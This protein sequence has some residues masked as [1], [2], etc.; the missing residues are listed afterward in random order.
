MTEETKLKVTG[1]FFE[2]RGKVFAT[3]GKNGFVE[4]DETGFRMMNLGLRLSNSE[5]V[6]VSLTAN[7]PKS[8]TDTKLRDNKETKE[9][10]WSGKDSEGKNKTIGLPYGKE[11]KEEK[12]R[13]IGCAVKLNKEDSVQYFCNYDAWQYLKDNLEDG[14]SV[15]IKGKVEFNSYENKDKVMVHGRKFVATAIF[16]ANEEIDFESDKFEKTAYFNQDIVF[17]G[18]NK[19]EDGEE[20]ATIDFGVV[21]W[22]GY[23]LATLPIVPKVA[24]ALNKTLKPYHKINING[25]VET[26]GGVVEVEVEDDDEWGTSNK[27]GIQHRPAVAKMI[28]TGAEQDSIDTELYSERGVDAWIKQNEEKANKRKGANSDNFKSQ[29]DFGSSSKI[30]PSE[31]EDS[32]W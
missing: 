19:P 9:V 28:V 8:L 32:A 27:V 15:F 7:K 20:L 17:L 12:F 6:F 30:R 25:I 23:E 13:P 2:F 16:V 10:Y 18:V 3:K 29:D 5:N 21:T 22:N 14:T 31:D 1:G 11:P 4:K 26:E 24:K